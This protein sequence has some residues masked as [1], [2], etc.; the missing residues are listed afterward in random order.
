[1]NIRDVA[2]INFVDPGSLQEG[3][4]IVRT[5]GSHVLLCL[6][7]RENGDVEAV[8]PFDIATVIAEALIKATQQ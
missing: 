4:A 7:L 8:L 1:M 5:T 3:V 6:S 2:T